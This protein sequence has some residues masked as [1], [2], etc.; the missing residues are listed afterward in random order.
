MI[1]KRL[2]VTFPSDALLNICKSFITPPLDCGN[3][4]HDKPNK[5]PFKKKLENIQ[6]KSCIAKT[7]AIKGTSREHF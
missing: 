7:G 6:H 1:I 3:V 2:S 4:I 5:M